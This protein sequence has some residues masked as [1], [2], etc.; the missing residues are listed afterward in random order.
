MLIYKTIW[1]KKMAQIEGKFNYKHKRRKIGTEYVKR[2]NGD[3]EVINL[4][5]K[6]PPGIPSFVRQWRPLCH[7]LEAIRKSL[8]MPLLDSRRHVMSLTSGYLVFR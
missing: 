6:T 5:Q 3:F 4:D 1:K 2:K 7:S 8:F